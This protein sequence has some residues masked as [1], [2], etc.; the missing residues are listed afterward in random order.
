M[1]T[2]NSIQNYV[3]TSRDK[4][5]EQL[6]KYFKEYMNLDEIEIR[7]S[8]SFGYLLQILSILSSNL[9][10]YSTLTHRD[11][12]LI[13]AQLPESIYDLSAY[14][15]YKPKYAIPANVDLL[16]T[17]DITN[18]GNNTSFSFEKD[19]VFVADDI[20]FRLP[21]KYN[22]LVHNNNYVT[23][24]KET[25]F[26]KQT[27]AS[28]ITNTNNVHKLYFLM[29][30]VQI[31]ANENIFYVDKSIRMYQFYKQN[32]PITKH[33]FIHKI[34]VFVNNILWTEYNNLFAMSST[35]E[36]YIVRMA[37]QS[38]NIYF[39]NGLFGKQPAPND[40]IKVI[41]HETTGERGNI[42]PGCITTGPAVYSNVSG[43]TQ[44]AILYTVT[45]PSPGYDGKDQETLDETR[46]NAIVNLKALNRLVSESDYRNLD[47]ITFTPGKYSEA[48]L[49]RSDLKCNEVVLYNILHFFNDTCVPT[50]TGQI[51]LASD[52]VVNSISAFSEFNI[53]SQFKGLCPFEIIPN[54][55]TMDATY[56]YIARDINIALTA[57]YL[58]ENTIIY[59]QKISVKSDY[60]TRKFTFRLYY[61]KDP[62]PNILTNYQLSL[63]LTQGTYSYNIDFDSSSPVL[64]TFLNLYYVEK[65]IPFDDISTAYINGTVYI[66]YTSPTP[67]NTP[68]TH[69]KYT[70]IIAIKLDLYNYTRSQMIAKR[71][72]NANIIGY[73]I[74]DVPL[75]EKNWF[76]DLAVAQSSGVDL[77]KAFEERLIQADIVNTDYNDIRM[78][79]TYIS[80]KYANT[81]GEL[82]NILYTK[83]DFTCWTIASDTSQINFNKLPADSY[84]L[85]NGPLNT[86]DNTTTIWQPSTTPTDAF[87][88]Q[89]TK[90]ARWNPATST[91]TFTKPVVSQS[92]Y[93][94]KQ[95]DGTTNLN[96]RLFFDGNEWFLPHYKTPLVISMIVY[97]QIFDSAY[98]D[99]IKSELYKFFKTNMTGIN[100]N[101]Y[102][103]EI[104]RFVQSLDNVVYCKLL[105]PRIDLLFN[106]D[107]DNLTKQEM[108]TYSPQYVHVHPNDINIEIQKASSGI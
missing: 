32:V 7:K 47:K 76:N 34:E 96:L 56:M 42:I 73:T 1:I 61:S 6:T 100:K 4:L 31:E 72:T 46:N 101:V 49:K 87:Y 80:H 23:I 28:E 38:V 83:P 71:D 69:C 55:A 20:K 70:A 77:R 15:G 97:L 85:V 79:N 59:G 52:P 102:R 13:T 35:S 66:T 25:D 105:E 81:I 74:L 5:K 9:L 30:L 89:H 51:E 103:S 90:I 93:I 95:P 107:V 40:Q 10:M 106:F 11:S 17:I 26:G 8:S 33:K 37:D 88:G 65:E 50:A 78:M 21:N 22:C 54:Y 82:S 67:P 48:I 68:V 2:H 27:I 16:V 94:M 98:K 29:N 60:T 91:W 3:T 62:D 63:Y 57:Q 44:L 41:I 36:G 43:G 24:T 18:M 39:G 75:I 99:L 45:N 64:D 92:V 53:D 86:L 108:I 58:D 104:I 19:M 14:L 12:N 84:V